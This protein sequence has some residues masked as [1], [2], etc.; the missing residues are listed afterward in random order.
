MAKRLILG[1]LL[2]AA[3]LA[4][5][6]GPA[7][8]P[9]RRSGTATVKITGTHDVQGE[10]PCTCG[11][12]LMADVHGVGKAGDGL[13]FEARIVTLGRL[14]LTSKVRKA[15]P[16]S[17]FGAVLNASDAS[18]LADAGPAARASFGADLWSATLSGTLKP[19][20]RPKPGE[21]PKEIRVEVKFDCT[22]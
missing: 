2:L 17:D 18:Y 19:M 5:R 9:V 22:R 6:A 1:W 21:K 14:Q 20:R 16:S 13:V 3:P 11:P 15:G 10:F 7:E 12:Y 8:A 4:G